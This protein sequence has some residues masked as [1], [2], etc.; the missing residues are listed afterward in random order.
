MS[1]QD[2]QDVAFRFIYFQKGFQI[3]FTIFNVN[4]KA[5]RRFKINFEY[6]SDGPVMDTDN[7]TAIAHAM[8]EVTSN[9]DNNSP[10]EGE[11]KFFK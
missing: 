5:F 7:T 10:D 11:G 1:F 8:N 2:A 3:K 6:L 4:L 9:Y